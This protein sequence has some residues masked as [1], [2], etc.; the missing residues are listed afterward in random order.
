MK[1][2]E[3]AEKLLRHPDFD[4]RFSFVERDNSR[5]GL[6]IR[7]FEDIDII[8]IGYSDKVILLGGNEE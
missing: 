3:L 2:K 1:A 8:D 7:S 5:W 6:T 4:V